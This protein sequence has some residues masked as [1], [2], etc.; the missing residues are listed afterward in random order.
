MVSCSQQTHEKLQHATDA[1]THRPWTRA[2]I[3]M[4]VSTLVYLYAQRGLG[5][6]TKFALTKETLPL[7][8]QKFPCSYSYL[9]DIKDYAQCR[10]LKCGRFVS[11]KL[12]EPKEAELLL[13][14]AQRVIE[15]SGGSS[16]GASILDMHTGAISH[17]EHFADVYK[18]PELAKEFKA[19][20]FKVFN[21]S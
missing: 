7:R 17:G 4:A 20:H 12:V 10:P 8:M 1:R 16:G 19:E 2:V 13:D 11:D 5:K 18:M 3:F 14:L 9:Q 21:V 15:K 6:E